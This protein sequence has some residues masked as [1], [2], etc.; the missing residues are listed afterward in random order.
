MNERIKE[1]AQQSLRETSINGCVDKV[2][3]A[4]GLT[5]NMSGYDGTVSKIFVDKFA[6]L[7]IRECAEVAY[8][9]G[10]PVVYGSERQFDPITYTGNQ[11][12]EH[13]GVEE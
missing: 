6:E 5:A 7:I 9:C 3:L 12:L 2:Y 13:F 8:E 11:I 10:P 4:D 1:L